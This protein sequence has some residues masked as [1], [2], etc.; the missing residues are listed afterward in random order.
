MDLRSEFDGFMFYAPSVKYSAMKQFEEGYIMSS[1]KQGDSK[2]EEE[3]RK[4]VDGE[5]ISHSP[6]EE[7]PY[8]RAQQLM[9]YW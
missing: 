2:E 6:R 5:N 1:T 8:L 3:R 7:R 4:S 9:S